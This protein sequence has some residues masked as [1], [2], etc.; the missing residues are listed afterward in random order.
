MLIKWLAEC[1]NESCWSDCEVTE[2]LKKAQ[3]RW[4][5]H[6]VLHRWQGSTT[7][8]TVRSKPECSESFS[9]DKYYQQ[10]QTVHSKASQVL[11][12][13]KEKGRR[14]E[15]DSCVAAQRWA[16]WE[17]TVLFSV[18]KAQLVSFLSPADMSAIMTALSS[19]AGL[20]NWNNFGHSGFN[21]MLT[22]WRFQRNSDD[23]IKRL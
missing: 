7:R 14:V 3:Q 1:M 20:L 12:D 23:S 9:N 17:D 16:I 8:R 21:I 2:P 4:E 13:S 15:E 5:K 22:I 19:P 10:A 11:Y 6:F 18:P